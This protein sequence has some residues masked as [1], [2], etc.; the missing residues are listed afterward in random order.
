MVGSRQ[1]INPFSVRLLQ[2]LFA[3]CQSIASPL[4]VLV[5]MSLPTLTILSLVTGASFD[6]TV[7]PSVFD[8][9]FGCLSLPAGSCGSGVGSARNADSFLD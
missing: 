4:S 7:G 9:L 3:D 6:W 1:P 2:Y 8:D 5:Q